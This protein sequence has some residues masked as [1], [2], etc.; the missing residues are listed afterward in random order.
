MIDARNLLAMAF[1]CSL[2]EIPTDA[3]IENFE[4]WDSLG[5]VR[6]VMTIEE[7]LNQTLGG[8]EI[9]G[10]VNLETIDQLLASVQQ[11]KQD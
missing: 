11:P 5:H 2:E 3:N 8:E 6:I 1:D 4:L 7:A 10:L 9:L